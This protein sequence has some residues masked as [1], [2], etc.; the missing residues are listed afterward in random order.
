MTAMERVWK[1]MKTKAIRFAE[2]KTFISEPEAQRAVLTIC[3]GERV[4]DPPPDA[5]AYLTSEL[6]RLSLEGCNADER[7]HYATPR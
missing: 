7:S 4:A 5:L 3:R 6:V 2:R 1:R